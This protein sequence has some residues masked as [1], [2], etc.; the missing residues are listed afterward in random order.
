[1]SATFPEN[2]LRW[3]FLEGPKK[4]LWPYEFVR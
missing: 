4:F 2:A 3:N 1:L